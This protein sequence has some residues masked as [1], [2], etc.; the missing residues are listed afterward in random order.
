MN[1][2]NQSS[3]LVNLLPKEGTVNYYGYIFSQKQADTHY[4]SL[5]N[6]IAWKND[7]VIIFGKLIITSRKTAW[8]GTKPFEYKYSHITKTALPFTPELLKIKQTIEQ[9]TRETYN[10]CLLNLYHDGTEGMTWHS[11]REKELKKNGIIASVTFGAERKFA[12]KHK[13]TKE[14]VSILLQH[15]SLLVMKDETQIH[16]HHSLPK[17]RK[18]QRPRINLT[19]RTIIT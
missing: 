9:K 8:Y 19:F 13:K 3:K 6:T 15:G 16:W 1:L 11:D 12:F 2:F 5:L 17:T 18:T 14:T 4:K 7:R 10:S